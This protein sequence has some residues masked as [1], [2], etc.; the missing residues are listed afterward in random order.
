[1]FYIV[2]ISISSIYYS[3]VKSI[4]FQKISN[5][6]IKK[7]IGIVND[8]IFAFSRLLEGR[9]AR[10]MEKEPSER[11]LSHFLTLKN[12]PVLNKYSFEYNEGKLELF[13]DKNIIMSINPNDTSDIGLL[14]REII[15]L[16]SLIK[17][18]V[19]L[20]KNN[21]KP[22]FDTNSG[23]EALNSMSLIN[24]NSI[25]DFEIKIKEK[26]EYQRFRGN[27]YFDGLPPWK[28]RDWIG[29]VITIGGLLFKVDDNI[30]RCSATNLRPKTDQSTFNLP[31]KLKYF[32]N[33]FDLGVYIL[34]LEDGELTSGDKIIVNQEI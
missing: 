8:R 23:S 32:Y 13:K 27:I 17:G 11:K 1:M 25:K 5:C 16:D 3:P 30:P 6:Q 15:N 20:L 31:Q 26:V 28:E 14:E 34:P 29:K 22:F 10:K 4:S 7:S 21:N 18:P 24:C 2:S 9:K 19:F 12:T 33:H